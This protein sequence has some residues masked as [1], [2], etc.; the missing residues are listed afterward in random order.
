MGDNKKDVVGQKSTHHTRCR[1]CGKS[2]LTPYLDLGDMPLANNLPNTKEEAI[3]MDR[4][5]LK[6]MF[7]ENCCLSQLSEVVDPRLLFS[8]YFYRS[9]MSNTYVNHCAEMA[10]SFHKKYNLTPAVSFIIDIAGNDG[11]LLN[12]FKKE[13][14]GVRVLNIDPAKNICAISRERGIPAIDEFLSINTAI[15]VL[16]SHGKADVITATNVFAHVNDVRDFI[17]SA[18]LLLHFNGVL[19]LEFPY[20]IDY[21]EGLEYNTTYHE[22]LSYMSI[23]P[24]DLLCKETGMKI[25]SVEKQNIHCGTVRVTIGHSYSGRDIENSVHEFLSMEDDMA[26][27]E[28]DRYMEFDDAACKNV[29]E[30]CILINDIRK[31]GKT[32]AAFAASAKGNT[33]LN[34]TGCTSEDIMYIVDDTPEK[35]FKFSPGTGIPILPVNELQNNPPD[36]L[37]ILAWN[38]EKE[39][40]ERVKDIYKGKF[41]IPVPVIKIID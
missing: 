15:N 35:Q 32:I 31:D 9:S 1:V 6:V 23:T 29:G 13:L 12:E 8:N 14:P 28:I 25:I 5:P 20:L 21:I 36:Y 2:T 26:F 40:L 39:I 16:V 22:H 38:F 41:I 27:T 18:K 4:F 33:L 7:C 37:L 24:L 34:L 11:T 17:L 30:I 3:N 10:R 19:V